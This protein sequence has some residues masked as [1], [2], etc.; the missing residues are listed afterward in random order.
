MGHKDIRTTMIYLHVVEQTGGYIKSPLDRPDDPEYEHDAVGRPWSDEGI[1]WDLAAR[2][3]G[4][5]RRPSDAD[6]GEE[7]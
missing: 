1:E 2:Q 7:D 5:T 4:R 3:W 6:R